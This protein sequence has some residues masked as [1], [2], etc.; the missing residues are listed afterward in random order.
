MERVRTKMAVR[1][2]KQPSAVSAE[3]VST[4]SMVVLLGCLA[5]VVWFRS[6]LSWV[7]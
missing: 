3:R 6:G 2:W 1:T 5:V 7:L 4:S